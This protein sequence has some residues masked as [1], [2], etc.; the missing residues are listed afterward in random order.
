M[1]HSSAQ[2]WPDCLPPLREFDAP[3]FD[4]PPLACDCHAHVFSPDIEQYPLIAN[5]SYMPVLCTED[6][7]KAML[8]GT[9]M[10]R[11]VLV[12]PS[13]YGTDNSLMIDVLRRHPAEL[14]GVA[15][16]APD[17][18][19]RELQDLHDVGVRG[20]RINLLYRGGLALDAVA[21]LA[22][23]LAASGWHIQLLID[24]RDLP[25]LRPE[26]AHP[27]LPIVI[28]HMG[29][30]PV[31]DGVDSAG[32]LALTRLV[33]DFGWW[34]KLSGA[35]RISHNFASDPSLT[36]W[37]QGLL[38]AGMDRLVWGSDWP[39]VAFAPTPNTG[40]LLNVLACRVG[41]PD[42]LQKIL[43]DNAAGLYDFPQ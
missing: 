6:D 38:N 2:T 17:V 42:V 40:A 33:T 39:H 35:Y 12:Q 25:S 19:D 29:H 26:F 1:E 34:V 8:L 28:D 41:N 43:V 37:T 36:D 4:V 16:V 31:D 20:V 7:Y 30:A 18:G 15:V 23:R 14:R 13:V 9:C 11:G 21:K 22:P 32:F 3:S 10:Q 27:D 5:R 24:A